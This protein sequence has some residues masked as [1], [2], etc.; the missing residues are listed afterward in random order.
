MKLI[1]NLKKKLKEEIR[2]KIIWPVNKL[3]IK[4]K[5]KVIGFKR[6]LIPSIR[7]K[8]KKSINILFFILIITNNLKNLLE[9]LKNIAINKIKVNLKDNIRFFK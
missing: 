4:R 3:A 8:K 2:S 6:L 5:I 7:I 1:K 9:A